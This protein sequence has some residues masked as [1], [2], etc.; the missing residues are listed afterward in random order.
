MRQI[1]LFLDKI[2][3]VTGTTSLAVRVILG[4]SAILVVI[5]GLSTWFD[6]HK[7]TKFHL[8]RYEEQAF[9]IS[10]TVMKSIEYPMLDGEMEDVNAILQRVHTLKDVLIV[11]LCD[12][13]QVIRYS[14]APANIGKTDNSEVTGRALRT[15]LLA[16][17][18][19]AE[20]ESK[21]L[22]HAMPI[23][24]EKN[25]YKCHGEEK[26]ILGALTVGINWVP[27]E[28]R[29]ALLMD[30]QIM[31][32][33][34][35]IALVGFFLTL[36]L[37]RYITGPLS[38]LTRLADEISRGNPG[39]DFGR[40]VKCW[41]IE[42]CEKECC[43]A[44]GNNDIMCWYVDK[45]L[46]KAQPSGKFP[47]K[48]DE[49][50]KC[51]VYR[52]HVGD[53][54]VQLADSFKH[55]LYRLN[56]SQEDLRQSEKKYRR[57]FNADPNPIFIL[58]RQTLA[59]L[60]ANARAEGHYGYFREEL[61]RMSFSDLGYPDDALEIAAGFREKTDQ[62]SI[63]FSKKQHR[64]KDGSIFYAN[65]HVCEAQYLERDALIAT[66]TDITKSV[67]KEA[68]LVQASKLAT[69]GEMAAGIAHELNQPLN[70]IKIGSDF[71]SEMAGSGKSMAEKDLKEVTGE[72]SGQVDR[73]AAI[74]SHMRD[75]AR[76]ADIEAQ[77]MDLN[78]PIQDVFKMLGQQLRLREI[79]WELH[80]QENLPPI[81][82]ENNRLEQVLINLVTNARDAME[83]NPA[84]AERLL[85]IHSFTDNNDV[86]VRV[87][88]TGHGIAANILD[89]IFEPFFTT[90]EVGK[91]TG[92]GL[93]I[94]HAIV[95]DYNGTLTVAS[96]EGAGTT[97]ELRFPAS[98]NQSA[99]EMR[100]IHDETTA[101]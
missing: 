10:D 70:V 30:W 77:E 19:Y 53:E 96:T 20:G 88:D 17:E 25:C 13:H 12:T 4:V 39:F 78:K 71:L 26:K 76:I 86:V 63:L 74:I 22:L 31:L 56:G 27:V 49:C 28:Q 91:G 1:G 82:G 75:F 3:A 6:M 69:L 52:A 101:H 2:R 42:H 67:Q 60:D 59:I 92:L 7:R 8:Q 83:K 29:M 23:A 58:D 85:T 81:M 55:M 37:S 57:L 61:L 47:N 72:I 33:V 90:K 38:L 97:F 54:M 9:E 98:R 93:S 79:K 89:R 18:L 35:S 40:K 99:D 24:N 36:F 11:N 48:L 84:G 5:I 41:E 51:R 46:C 80:L 15:G 62:S 73:A 43:P 94:S 14:G 64:R 16:K 32:T 21:M 100:G 45:T 66:T 87:S 50:R 34:I 44:H 65:I 68:Q 95:E